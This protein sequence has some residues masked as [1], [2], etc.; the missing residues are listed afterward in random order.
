[1]KRLLIIAIDFYKSYISPYL[2]SQCRFYPTCSQ[3]AKQAIALHGARKGTF[4][5]L[6]RIIKCHPFH[7]GGY[8]PVPKKD[9]N[10]GV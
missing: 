5:F 3:Y 8:D 7:S 4:L 2:P 10:L 9:I 6:K 1:M